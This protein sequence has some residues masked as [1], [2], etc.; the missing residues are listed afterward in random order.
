ME[1]D[2]CFFCGEPSD[3]V[4]PQCGLVASCSAEHYTFHRPKG[5]CFP[6]RVGFSEERGMH[7]VAARNI[8]VGEVISHFAVVNHPGLDF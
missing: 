3:S 6:F 2:S 5:R 8:K 7:L 4:C 1:M